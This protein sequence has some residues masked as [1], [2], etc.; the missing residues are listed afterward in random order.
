MYHAPRYDRRLLLGPKRDE[1][2]TLDEV[3]LYGQD[4]FGDPDYVCIYGLRPDEWYA[5]GVRLMGRTAVE[6][7]RDPL[8]RRMARDIAAVADTAGA[9]ARLALDLFAGSGNTLY[10][11]TRET[12]ARRGIGFELD[13]GV[14]RLARGNLAGLGLDAELRPQGYAGGLAAL[15]PP[16]EDL[17]IVFVAP[18]W[19]TP[20]ARGPA[21]T[22]AGPGRRRPRPSTW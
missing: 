13:P 10:W 18:P 2:L 16:G 6:C 15:G 1:I 12:G 5:R 8:A 17:V 20:S 11:I 22:W 19:V 14:F 4:S 21:W 9:A 7:T 3:R